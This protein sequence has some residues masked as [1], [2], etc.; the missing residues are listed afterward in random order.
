MVDLDDLLL[1]PVELF[2]QYPG[3]LSYFQ[4]R[5]TWINIDEYQDINYAQYQLIRLLCNNGANLCAIGDP[6]QA[7]Y[8][9]RGA[10]TSYFMRFLAEYQ[11]ARTFSLQKNY[12]SARNILAASNNVIENAQRYQ[13]RPIYSDILN[14]TKVEI[15]TA[16]TDKAE[17]EYVVHQIE[18]MV[19]GTSYFSIDSD[20]IKEG[21]ES[22]SK[23]TFSDFAVLYRLN[24]QS[25]LLKEAFDRSGMPY[26]TSGEQPLFEREDI[27]GVINIVRLLENPANHYLFFELLKQNDINIDK[28]LSEELIS[29]T[30]TQKIPV[31]HNVRECISDEKTEVTKQNALLDLLSRLD[32]THSLMAAMR[33]KELI[34]YIAEAFYTKGYFEDSRDRREAWE[35]LM[36]QIDGFN[37]TITEFLQQAVIHQEADDYR[38]GD[39]IQLMTL[40]TAKGLEFPVV[41]IVG[42]ENNL[43]PYNPNERGCDADEERRLFYVGMTRACDTLILTRAKQRF[44]YGETLTNPPSPFLDEIE[45]SLKHESESSHQKK[46]RTANKSSQLDLF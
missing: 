26:Q 37:G 43:L 42:C 23:W 9:F 2:R 44:L 39:R 38:E 28:W 46:A 27:A 16:P 11:G 41:F 20:R 29:L 31:W 7:I 22:A 34:E 18:S 5:Y 24:A 8:G 19:G 36:L 25:R 3:L 6:N 45:Q 14:N 33:L 12:R 30:R 35:R 17:A 40:H 10:S 13:G 32:K 15:Y 1:K 21:D 4:N